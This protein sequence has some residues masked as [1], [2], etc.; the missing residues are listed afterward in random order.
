VP[1]RVTPEVTGG[2][3]RVRAVAKSVFRARFR[4][5]CTACQAPIE[6][7]QPAAYALDERVVHAEHHDDPD[8]R[9]AGKSLGDSPGRG[10]SKSRSKGSS[11]TAAGAAKTGSS[12]RSNKRG[13]ARSSSAQAAGTTK[14]RRAT[15]A[16]TCPGCSQRIAVGDSI[17]TWPAG[18]WAHVGCAQA[19]KERLAILAGD[20]FA[21]QRPSDYRLGSSPSNSRP[22]R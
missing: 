19:S 2:R 6:P 21:S 14:N 4:S 15:M 11:P 7:G 22:R 16:S 17:A 8:V 9:A 12:S 1:W 18:G 10:Q 20:R 5:L 13:K 3:R